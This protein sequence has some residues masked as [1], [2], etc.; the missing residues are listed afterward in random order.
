[1]LATYA[2]HNKYRKIRDHCHYTEGYRGAVHS[3]CNIKYSAPKEITVIFHNR[4]KYDYHFII[5]EQKNLK[6]NLLVYMKILK[7]V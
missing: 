4:S 7:N 3:I 2:S 1:M 6:G 5:K